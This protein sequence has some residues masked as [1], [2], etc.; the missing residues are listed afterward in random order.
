M[1]WRQREMHLG[2][3]ALQDHEPYG[4]PVGEGD[5][6]PEGVAIE[7]QRCLNVADG[8]AGR[9]AAKADRSSIPGVGVVGRDGHGG[10]LRIGRRS[11]ILAGAVPGEGSGGRRGGARLTGRACQISR[12]AVGSGTL[13]RLPSG[14]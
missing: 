8:N 4:V 9:G 7:A 3:I 10:L 6:H 12:Y 2:G 5:R 11:L 14:I 13:G 1:P